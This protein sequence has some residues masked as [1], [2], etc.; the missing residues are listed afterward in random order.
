M[1]TSIINTEFLRLRGTSELEQ[2]DEHMLA[3]IGVERHGDVFVH[4]GRVVSKVRS[5]EPRDFITLL[6]SALGGNRSVRDAHV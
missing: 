5:W 6:A 2:L 1:L 4:E 3:D